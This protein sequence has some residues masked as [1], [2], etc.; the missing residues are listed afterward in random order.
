MGKLNNHQSEYGRVEEAGRMI[1]EEN[2]K[3][4]KYE[5]KGRREEMKVN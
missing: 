3:R 2:G 5:R 4:N 1:K